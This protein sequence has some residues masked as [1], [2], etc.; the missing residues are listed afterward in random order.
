MLTFSHSENERFQSE[1]CRIFEDEKNG[2]IQKAPV[3]TFDRCLVKS[4]TDYSNESFPTGASILDLM[5]CSITFNDS[6]SLLN[7]L[8]KFVSEILNKQSQC[9]IKLVR[10]KNG[11]KNIVNWKSLKDAEYCYIKLNVT[12]LNEMKTQSQIVEIQFLLKSLLKAKKMGHKYYAIKRKKQFVDSVYDIVYNENR[13]YRTYKNKI[14]AI[15]K[16]KNA[17]QLA[18]Q[19]FINPNLVFSFIE[20]FG[21]TYEPLLFVIGQT[22]DNKLLSLFLSSLFHFGETVLNQTQDCIDSNAN[23]KKSL[24][25]KR[26]LNF[27]SF[28]PYQMSNGAF[29]K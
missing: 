24:F 25:L 1:I 6:I 19:L 13:D 20:P 16:S 7:G 2:T 10:V 5:R 26:Y 28:A 21:G 12:Y 17:N 3:K 14:L 29:V 11:F 4:S 22:G 15:I 27:N 8:N 9:L 23:K 18:T